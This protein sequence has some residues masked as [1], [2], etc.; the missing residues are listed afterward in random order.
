MEAAALDAT[1]KEH[2]GYD[3]FRPGQRE[4]ALAALEHRDVAVF[5]TTGAGKSLCYQLPAV[6]SGKTV[7]V[8][9]P[10]ISLMQDQ[11]HRFNATVGAQGRFQACFLG[12]AQTDPSIEAKALAGHFCLIYLTPEKLTGTGGDFL[13]KLPLQSL[14]LVAI[15][16]AH[17]ISEWG[18]DFRPSYRNLHAIRETLPT[19]PLMTLTATASTRVQR[20][21]LQQLQLRDPLAS[22]SSS[23]RPNLHLRCTRKTSKAADLLRI[24]N[25]I[26]AH[27]GSTI[28]YAMTQSDAESVAGFL[29]EKLAPSLKVACYHGGLSMAAREDAH[30]AFLNGQVQVVVATVAFGMGIDKPDV[31]RI[32]HYGPPKTV[33]EYFQQIGRAG[34][35]GLDSVCELITSDGDFRQY[36]S[37]FYT[38]SLSEENIKQVAASTEALR[39]F[40]SCS[41]CRWR[42]LLE[43]FGETPSYRHCGL[44]DNSVA[45]GNDVRDFRAAVAPILH[46]VAATQRF[47]QAL[48]HLLQIIT[49]TWKPKGVNSITGTVAAAQPQIQQLRQALPALMKKEVV[50]REL[51]VSLCGAGYLQR[52]VVKTDNPSSFC[53][54]FEVYSLTEAGR[55]ALQS[56][57]PVD[58]PI[59]ATI[60]QQ[61]ADEEERRSAREREV[62]SFGL[63]VRTL[64]A[65]QMADDGPVLWYI[66]KLKHWKASGKEE[67]LAKADRHE[68]LRKEILRWR[69]EAAVRL[70]LA[71]AAV[72]SEYS[73]IALTYV[74]PTTVEAIKSVG[75]RISGAEELAKIIQKAKEEMKGAGENAEAEERTRGEPDSTMELP[76]GSVTP[77]RKWP[78]AVYKPGRRGAKVSWELSYERF[79]ENESLQSIAMRPASGAPIQTN[80]VRGHILTA[81][82]FGKPVDLQRLFRESEAVLPS[83]AEWRQL[84]EAAAAN[85]VDFSA[86]IRLKEILPLILGD[87]VNREPS[88]KSD[89]DKELEREWYERMRIW[90]AFRKVGYVPSFAGAKRQRLN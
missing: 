26:E 25:D 39:N 15:D 35:D 66:R 67:L 51:I 17:C 70:R 55:T 7:L 33:E 14:L 68:A 46:A 27:R 21:I 76:V 81:W 49:G 50:V 90:E 74:Q 37:D 28:V 16:E 53:K 6:Q 44:C 32:I 45:N 63:D 56:N 31:R 85:K 65:D 42:W 23:Y 86:D 19:I 87:K 77:P 5:W 8:V 52:T 2:F 69:A 71:P 59:T 18:H 22:H 57:A 24:A 36:S 82:T 11:V 38:K 34:R 64:S 84:E 20:D 4:V 58:L 54:T 80:T 29:G 13:R 1:L 48:T 43:Y 62:S 72:L 40:A 88:L 78:A 79:L 12:S 3:S 47:P 89:A 83:E 73:C 41:S 61:E 9:S 30:V 10:L 60:R 75:V